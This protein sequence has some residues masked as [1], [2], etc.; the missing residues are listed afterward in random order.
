M[1]GI[2]KL[3]AAP[4][5]AI[6]PLFSL[7]AA[8]PPSSPP[9]G[10][11]AD[12]PALRV[13]GPFTHENL[14]VY[15]VSGATQDSRRFIT[16][17]EGLKS[18]SVKLREKG[19]GAAASVNELEIE[20]SSDDWLYLQAGD[21]IIGGQ[22]DRTIAIDVAIAPHSQ[23]QPIAAFCVEHGRWTPRAGTGGGKAA[24]SFQESNAIAGSN[25]MKMSIQEHADQS[26]VWAEVS[27]DEKR[28]SAKVA[29]PVAAS[30]GTYDAI[31]SNKQ[32]AAS[33]ADYVGTLLGPIDK[34][35]DAV[36]IVVAID[37]KIQSADVR[38]CSTSWPESSWS[39][40][41]RR[42][43]SRRSRRRPSPCLPRTRRARS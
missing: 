38:R 2:S 26:K 1:L 18:K 7:F 33:R 17:A 27:R 42:R 30:T 22:Q 36:G 12:T 13:E 35:K 4:L 10:P 21:V 15:V 24:F 19:A 32:I 39:R 43:S 41:R 3:A 6:L 37:G 23:P 9:P 20:N 31:V 11:A 34:A 14:S 5:A 28:A 29:A 16:L 25:A 40:T 8:A